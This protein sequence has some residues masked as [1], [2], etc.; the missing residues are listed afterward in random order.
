MAFTFGF[1]G[2]TTILGKNTNQNRWTAAY[3]TKQTMENK[4]ND[5]AFP[6]QFAQDSLGRILAP[7]PG[8]SKLEFFSLML[9]PTY[10]DIHQRQDLSIKGSKVTPYDAAIEGANQLLK[11]LNPQEDEKPSLQIVS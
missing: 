7:V 9:L 6:P 2:T 5:P 4:Y 3:R 1:C 11:R 10:L 8:M